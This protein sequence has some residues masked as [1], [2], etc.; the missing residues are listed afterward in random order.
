MLKT[1]K[2]IESKTQPNEGRV[3]VG[4]SSGARRVGSGNRIDDNKFAGN[5]FEDNEVGKKIQ[6]WSKSRNL[7]K[8]KKT[9]GSDFF[10][11]RAKLAF[12]KLR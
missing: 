11:P 3:G 1:L 2:S 9:V 6:K 10:I 7:S 8:S 12:T 4:R 5:E